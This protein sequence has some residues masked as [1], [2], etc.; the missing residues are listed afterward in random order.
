MTAILLT[1]PAKAA[2][3]VCHE[4]Q[5]RIWAEEIIGVLN[6]EG[7]LRDDLSYDDGIDIHNAI[8]REIKS[9]VSMA[10]THPEAMKRETLTQ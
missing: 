6:I 5:L 1:H 8:Q 4:E 7:W 3:K 9:I 10:F 2:E